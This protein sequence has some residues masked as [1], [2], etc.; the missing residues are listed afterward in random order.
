MNK[1]FV[2]GYNGCDYFE[3]WYDRDQFQNTKLYYFDNG[4][5]K[6]SDT[7]KKDLVYTTTRNI[8]CAGGWN[9]MCDYAFNTLKL[10]KI[11]IGQE[12]SIIS[13]EILEELYNRCNPSTICGT[14]DNSFDFAVFSLHKETFLKLGRFDENI[15][16]AGC[17]DDDYKH[18]CR[19]NNI[20]IESLGVPHSYNISIAN[21]D[22]CKPSETSIYNAKYVNEKWGNYNFNIPFND[23]NYKHKPTNMF[24]KYYGQTTEWP[25]EKEFKKL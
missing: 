9:L 2:L 4:Q 13:E 12:D 18:L 6:L 14:Y 20:R 16:F 15:L 3:N 22:R 21:N 1:I 19:L 5:Q 8:G 10:D 23:K 11:I 17:E 24:K 25:S 7:L